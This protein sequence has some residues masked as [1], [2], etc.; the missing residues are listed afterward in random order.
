M[1]DWTEH[2][3]E[4]GEELIYAALSLQTMDDDYVGHFTIELGDVEYIVS[5]RKHTDG[6]Y[7]K[8]ASSLRRPS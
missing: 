8:L 4:Y 6:Y 7:D 2:I 3:Q 5:I 1:A